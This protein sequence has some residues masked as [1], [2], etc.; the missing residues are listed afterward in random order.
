MFWVFFLKIHIYPPHHTL[1]DSDFP[2]PLRKVGEGKIRTLR[3]FKE[4][5]TAPWAK[6][7]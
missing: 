5:V 3:R 2:M 1:C 6:Q 4:E 7:C